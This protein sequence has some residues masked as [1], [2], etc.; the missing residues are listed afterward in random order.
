MLDID[1]I[2]ITR[3]EFELRPEDGR[4][5]IRCDLRVPQGPQR[6]SAVILCHGFKGFR[7]WGSFPHLARALAAHGHAAISVD[8]SHNGVGADGV[9]FSALEL[10][11]AQTHTRNVEEIRMVVDAVAGGELIA[12]VRGIGLWGH[13]RGGGEAI[14]AAAQ[15]PRIAALVTWAAVASMHRWSED[16]VARWRRGERVEIPNA[17]TGQPMPI[18]PDYLRD[19]EDNTESLDVRAAAAR[20]GVPWL[21]IHGEADETVRVE[22]GRSLFEMAGE[23]AELLLVEGADHTFGARHPYAGATP[24]LGTAAE[25]TLQWFDEHLD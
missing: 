15:D 11:A 18:G 2:R 4:P 6:R 5:P 7:R 17:R 13:S 1:S 12:G 9:D 3:T 19:L 20:V 22:E 24:E 8:F 16:Q 21:L 23:S 25:A 14:L 10:F